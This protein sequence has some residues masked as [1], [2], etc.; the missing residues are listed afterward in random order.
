ML[1]KMSLRCTNLPCPILKPHENISLLFQHEKFACLNITSVDVLRRRKQLLC[2]R[3]SLFT[4]N[5]ML[6]V[7]IKRQISKIFL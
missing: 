6:F 5:A 4:Y 3:R 1:H 2:L 7:K